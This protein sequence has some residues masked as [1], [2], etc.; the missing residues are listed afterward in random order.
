[1]FVPEN[2]VDFSLMAVVMLIVGHVPWVR[3]VQWMA[4]VLV[5]LLIRFLVQTGNAESCR[6]GVPRFRAEIVRVAIIS[7][8]IVRV[9]RAR[10]A[11]IENVGLY[12]M[13]AMISRAECVRRERY[14]FTFDPIMIR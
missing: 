5:F 3:F 13:G 14:A 7:Q 11:G 8:A 1:M 9:F 4:S 12:S 2:H 6:M 10:V